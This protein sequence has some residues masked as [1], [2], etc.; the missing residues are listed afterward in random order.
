MN[1][2]AIHEEVPGKG[3][4]VPDLG[5]NLMC[6]IWKNFFP[7]LNCN[8]VR[9]FPPG[10][11]AL[12]TPIGHPCPGKFIVYGAD[13]RV[14][15][16]VKGIILSMEP[17]LI[18]YL[19]PDTNYMNMVIEGNT[20]HPELLGPFG[21]RPT[22]QTGFDTWVKSV[23]D[24]CEKSLHIPFF[25]GGLIPAIKLECL[26]GVEGSN[27]PGGC[28]G[29]E[30]DG[31]KVDESDGGL[32]QNDTNPT[33]CIPPHY[34]HQDPVVTS[35]KCQEK[36]REYTV[37][38]GIRSGEILCRILPGDHIKLT[39]LF[40]MEL[41][42]PMWYSPMCH[43]PFLT[44]EVV[45]GG[46]F[47]LPVTVDACYGHAEIHPYN[48]ESIFYEPVAPTS[49]FN[50]ETHTVVAPIYHQV[51]TCV[52][53]NADFVDNL[54]CTR[55]SLEGHLIDRSEETAP[56]KHFFLKAPPKPQ[57]CNFRP[58]QLRFEE[59][60]LHTTPTP[61]FPFPLPLPIPLPPFLAFS[62]HEIK[63]DGVSIDVTAIG[64]AVNN[65]TVFQATWSTTW[66]PDMPPSINSVTFI[67]NIVGSGSSQVTINT[68]ITDDVG[69]NSVSATVRGPSP[70]TDIIGSG[71]PTSMRLISGTSQDGTWQG[72][73]T[74]PANVPDGTY[75]VEV[76]ALDSSGQPTKNSANL[77]LDRTPPIVTG[78]PDRIPD[79]GA[80]GADGWYSR[81][82]TIT[83]NGND[84]SSGSGVKGCDPSTTYSG[85]DS[86][87]VVVT[88]HCI[89]NAGNTGAGTF[90]FNYDGTPPDTA[91]SAA[92]DGDNAPVPINGPTGS[93]ISN[94]ITVTFAG[95]DNFGVASFQCSLDDSAFS[96]TNCTSPTTT[97]TNLASGT[98]N[99]KVRAVDLAGNI[100]PTPA[101]FSWKILT[102]A[103]AV[104]KLIDIF[105][106]MA[107]PNNIKTD[108][109]SPLQQALKILK[110]NNSGNDKAVCNNL[111]ALLRRVNANLIEA[112]I[113]ITKSQTE[114]LIHLTSVIKNRLDCQPL[115]PQDSERPE[116]LER[117]EF[118]ERPEPL[119]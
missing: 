107:I 103:E 38:K 39:G 65:P 34:S 71:L 99:F 56:V 45:P 55:N 93:T 47:G 2:Y 78:I 69:V 102:P 15:T 51:I 94:K 21:Q 22:K 66:V 17:E 46:P 60:I 85:P 92:V 118:L 11:E 20:L 6:L 52:T 76:A 30:S 105:R 63:A 104:Q 108:F 9:C 67:P 77:L 110:D 86:R 109:V 44:Q 88:G 37:P 8:L 100:D 49:N 26:T 50:S 28:G 119:K 40:I 62:T 98:H 3:A 79:S 116:I 106:S 87:P 53:G 35:G 54:D 5:S 114:T 111:D 19:M 101:S 32:V 68:K 1:A 7:G 83:W 58:C 75:T 113:K 27:I 81:P 91:L 73:F 82:L 42:H 61:P 33:P 112:D 29:P 14:N 18:M 23:R 74:F 36:G 31:C 41:Q 84:G 96:S 70:S 115:L 25:C 16:E 117:P 64:A 72:V 43:A 48:F 80:V 95:S 10:K 13:P 90:T 24:P 4:G 97:L 89:D 57:D 59:N 12:W